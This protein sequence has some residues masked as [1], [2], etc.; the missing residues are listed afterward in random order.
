MRHIRIRDKPLLHVLTDVRPRA[1]FYRG[2][3][4]QQI[5]RAADVVPTN[6]AQV[7]ARNEGRR[8]V[9]VKERRDEAGLFAAVDQR[10]DHVGGDIWR[11]HAQQDE[12]VAVVIPQRR[13]GVVL[14][15]GLHHRAFRIG[16]LAVV[17]TSQ[18]RPKKRA[19]Q[20]GVKEFLL[21][22]GTARDLDLRKQLLPGCRGLRLD[23]PE[24]SVSNLLFKILLGVGGAHKREP[25]LDLHGTIPV[26]EVDNR[27]LCFGSL[28]PLHSS[29]L[30]IRDRVKVDLLARG[31]I[32]LKGLIPVLL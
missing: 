29:D 32:T 26:G 9:A 10:P 12:L 14:K 1:A 2:V 27:Q 31:L 7:G 20:A 6:A 22:L 17:I 24:A 30:V 3:A 11:D 25:D 28:Q 4:Q 13:Q 18:R 16:V 5:V 15:T 23:L 19:I 8:M 21:A